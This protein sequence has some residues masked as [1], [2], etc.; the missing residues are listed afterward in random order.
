MRRSRSSET[1][2]SPVILQVPALTTMRTPGQPITQ[3][4]PQFRHLACVTFSLRERPVP[5]IEIPAVSS[6][7]VA[8]P[9]LTPFFIFTRSVSTSP[10]LPQCGQTTLGEFPRGLDGIGGDDGGLGAGGT[11]TTAG[12][13]AD[14]SRNSPQCLHF[15]ATVRI[16]SPQNGQSLV[17]LPGFVVLVAF[18]EVAF[19]EDAA[20]LVALAG[21][22]PPLVRSAI[23]VTVLSDA[24]PRLDVSVAEST[25][26]AWAC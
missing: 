15:T 16:D 6:A 5:S 10:A 23:S 13:F 12:G 18:A 24:L 4:T 19:V 14:S 20:G 9:P 25:P 8:F 22:E 17:G 7:A 3:L 11:G 21:L 2:P 1:R 26:L